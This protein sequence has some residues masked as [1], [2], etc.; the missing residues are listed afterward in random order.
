MSAKKKKHK[1]PAT[2]NEQQQKNT[3]KA[4]SSRKESPRWYRRSWSRRILLLL[5]LLVLCWFGRSTLAQIPLNLARS[6]LVDHR[7]EDALEWLET[8][9]W[10]DGPSAEIEFYQA[11]AFRNLG[12][13]NQCHDHLQNALDRGLDPEMVRREQ[14]LAFAQ[15]GQMH[16]AEPYLK[17]LLNDPRG[18][19]R[20]ICEAYV[21]GYVR[22]HD[23][24]SAS[25]ILESWKKDFPEDYRPWLLLGKINLRET[26]WETAYEEL[27]RAWEL[28][29]GLSEVAFFLAESMLGEK[30]YEEARTWFSKVEADS[31][32]YLPAQAR[33]ARSYRMAGELEAAQQSILSALKLHPDDEELLIELG[34]IQLDQ[35]NYSAAVKSFRKSDALESRDLEIR[36][37]VATALQGA[38]EIEEAELQ[39]EWLKQAQA[40]TTKIAA[41]KLEVFSDSSNIEA[42]SEIGRLLLSYGNSDEGIIWLNSVFN[43][44]PNHAASHRALAEYYERKIDQGAQYQK[45]AE[46]HRRQVPSDV[47]EQQK[48]TVPQ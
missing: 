21:V 42:R 22:V 12:Q 44:D 17:Q 48:T 46:Q 18:D 45:L 4:P 25:L 23:L 32:Y 41:L 28:N 3:E 26:R 15:S 31:P 9:H 13:F 5:V 7:M 40:A 2:A 33:L 37:A 39:F 6:A 47:Q 27:L 14:W 10:M 11:R 30:R 36:Y 38:Q 24:T 20:E 43:H 16:K 8:A 29:P 1:P 19:E 34:N 35:G